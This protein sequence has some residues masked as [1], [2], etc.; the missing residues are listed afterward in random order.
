M[1]G[2]GFLASVGGLRFT[3]YAVPIL[4]LGIAF[5]ITELSSKMPTKK[6]QYL[7]MFAFTFAILYPNYKHIDSYRVPT[8]FNNNE[9][10]VL[11]SLKKTAQR[12]DYVI[13]WWDYGY[14]IRYYADVKTLIDGSKHGGSV[15]FP[16]SF[17][18]THTQSEAAKMARFDVE[19][20]EQAFLEKRTIPNI[21]QMT[22]DY[23]VD[24]TND[25][26]SLLQVDIKLPKKT[27]D[28]Y[29]YLPYRMLNI[30]PT[31]NLFSNLDL[32]T[33]EK[34]NSPFFFVSKNYKDNGKTIDL[35][36]NIILDKK[37]SS[38]SVRGKNVQIKRFVTTA[39][40]TKM[41]LQTKMQ[42][43]HPSANLNVIYM[44]NYKSFLVIDDKTY[45][46]MYIQLMVLETYNKNLF[47]LIDNNPHVKVYKLKI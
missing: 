26:L 6:L 22:K 18:L 12:E 44:S 25:F 20:T 33:G 13:G 1:V 35:S 40:D 47:E 42:M 23:D 17:M 38:L 39:Y 32:M 43:L 29:F 8:V 37:T 9:V 16:V 14:P 28:I 3:I 30:Y 11:D 34:R 31:V 36:N 41:N 46:S 7:S 10:K 4:A 19:Y 15:N 24:D 5:L 27:R 21:E 2:L 45:N